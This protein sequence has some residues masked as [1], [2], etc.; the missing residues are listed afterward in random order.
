MGVPTVG[1]T[2]LMSRVLFL[3]YLMCFHISHMLI[4]SSC[5]LSYFT[6][7]SHVLSHVAG[8]NIFRYKVSGCGKISLTRAV[9]TAAEKF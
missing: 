3:S 1:R 9:Q 8:D 4:H 2:F 7:M 5:A 6:A